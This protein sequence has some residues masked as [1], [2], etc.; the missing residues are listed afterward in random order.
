MVWLFFT[1][2]NLSESW[3]FASAHCLLALSFRIICHFFWKNCLHFWFRVSLVS[4]ISV[5][6]LLG[7]IGVIAISFGKVVHVFSD[8]GFGWW[9]RLLMSCI[10]LHV[11]ISYHNNASF[12]C[13]KKSCYL[14][15]VLPASNIRL[16]WHVTEGS[17]WWRLCSLTT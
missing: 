15:L 4:L 3:F 1:L 16:F 2:S 12:S 13:V 6:G 5:G 7:F 8:V 9:I 14:T 10:M 17:I 11:Y